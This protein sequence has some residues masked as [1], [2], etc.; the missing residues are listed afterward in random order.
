[1]SEALISL[2]QMLNCKIGEFDPGCIDSARI[3]ADSEIE[4]PNGQQVRRWRPAEIDI[5]AAFEVPNLAVIYRPV[6]IPGC[7][8]QSTSCALKPDLNHGSLRSP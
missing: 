2:W 4:P 5:D 1:M 6:T 8:A 3:T 7:D